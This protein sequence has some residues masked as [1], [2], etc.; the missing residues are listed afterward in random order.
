LARSPSRLRSRGYF[1]YY[2]DQVHLQKGI[3]AYRRKADADGALPAED[4]IVVLNFSGSDAE[5]WLPF[6]AP[7]KWVE[8]IDGTRPPVSIWSNDQWSSVVVPSNYGGVYK[9][10]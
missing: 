4:L 10:T 3:L 5:I 6:P 2:Y 1:Y 8:Q 7:G 9:R